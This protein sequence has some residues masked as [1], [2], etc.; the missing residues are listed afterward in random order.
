MPPPVP[1]PPSELSSGKVC[2]WT[3]QMCF[4]KLPE[5]SERDSFSKSSPQ[6]RETFLCGRALSTQEREKWGH[7]RSAVLQSISTRSAGLRSPIREWWLNPW[8]EK[9]REPPEIQSRVSRQDTKSCALANSIT[10]GFNQVLCGEM[11]PSHV[12]VRTSEREREMDALELL[13]KGVSTG[14]TRSGWVSLLSDIQIGL[15]VI[16]GWRRIKVCPWADW[17]EGVAF[18]NCQRVTFLPLSPSLSSVPS[19]KRLS[20]KLDR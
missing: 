19:P 12:K 18:E 20:A 11:E 16:P 14:E 15:H 10:L 5:S 17:L 1:P 4:T 6:C 8:D 2:L 7:P 13:L 9:R 3:E